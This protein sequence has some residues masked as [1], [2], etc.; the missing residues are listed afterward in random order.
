MQ[1]NEGCVLWKGKLYAACSEC[2]AGAM[3]SGLAPRPGVGS[4]AESPLDQCGERSISA[5]GRGERGSRIE[6]PR[7]RARQPAA[8]RQSAL[9]C[10]GLYGAGPASELQR[11]AQYIE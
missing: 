11:A 9:L 8:I 10:R 7:Y 2:Q 6:D 4:G 3:A 1:H 5:I